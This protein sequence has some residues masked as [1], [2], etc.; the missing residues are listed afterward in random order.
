[1]LV[2]VLGLTLDAIIM[3]TG[4][5]TVTVHQHMCHNIRENFANETRWPNWSNI[6]PGENFHVLYMIPIKNSPNLHL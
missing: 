4:R 1:M 3:H 5:V 6:S 2:N